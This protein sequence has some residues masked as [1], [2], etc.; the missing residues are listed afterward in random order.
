LP[1]TGSH[2]VEVNNRTQ[3]TYL[4]ATN[5]IT[6]AAASGTPTAARPSFLGTIQAVTPLGST[7][8][9]DEGYWYAAPVATGVYVGCLYSSNGSNSWGLASIRQKHTGPLSFWM[10][11][12]GG[13]VVYSVDGAADVYVNVSNDSVSRFVT[14]FTPVDGAEHDTVVYFVGGGAS[15]VFQVAATTINAAAIARRAALSA[16]GDSNWA[17][18]GVSTRNSVPDLTLCAPYIV[19]RALGCSIVNRG[20]GFTTCAVAANNGTGLFDQVVTTKAAANHTVDIPDT[21]EPRSFDVTSGNP[22]IVL[23]YNFCNDVADNWFAANAANGHEVP[24]DLQTALADI[25]GYFK[26]GVLPALKK[27][28]TISL[29][30]RND[31]ADNVRGISTNPA[32]GTWN[33]AIKDANTATAD[34][35]FIYVPTE[36]VGATGIHLGDAEMAQ[37]ANDCLPFASTSGFTVS[38]ASSGTVGSPVTITYTRAASSTWVSGESVTTS[39]ASGGTIGSFTFT[40]G[41]TTGTRTY[42]PASAGP[43]TLTHTNSQGWTNPAPDSF[44]ANAEPSPGSEGRRFRGGG[45][46]T[47]IAAGAAE[48]MERFGDF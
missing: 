22:S 33:A 38:V 6:L 40:P 17:G 14:V 13:F 2:L 9:V 20:I 27:F 3:N 16:Y 10:F 7:S 23:M 45:G 26:G 41:Q 48:S 31:V 47:A 37:L 29:C 15:Q 44:T 39:D 32:P 5:G 25:Q 4:D 8:V 36:V 18:A 21:S 1:D 19:A 34:S 24:S 42:T 46:A 43:K 12:G 35:K 28:L 30:P 11:C